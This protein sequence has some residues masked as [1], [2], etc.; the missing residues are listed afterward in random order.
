MS[1]AQEKPQQQPYAQ[2]PVPPAG[3]PA[4]GYPVQ[5]P[6]P[7]QPGQYGY[8]GQYQQPYPQQYV[9]QQQAPGLA[10]E[11][12][13]GPKPVSYGLRI[14]AAVVGL[15]SLM[16]GLFSAM[17]AFN[18]PAGVNGLVGFAV[19]LTI[20]GAL[21]TA[22]L[23]VLLLVQ[24]RAEKPKVLAALLAGAAG[25]MA[26]EFVAKQPL[27]GLVA[28]AVVILAGLAIGRDRRYARQA[29]GL[30]EVVFR[31]LRNATAVAALVQGIFNLAWM[32]SMGFGS[33]FEALGSTLYLVAGP[34]A[35]AAGA[36]LLAD[37]RLFGDRLSVIILGAGG[38]GFL[39]GAPLAVDTEAAIVNLIASIAALVL[40]LVLLLNERGSNPAAWFAPWPAQQ[41]PLPHPIPAQPSEQQ[42][43][44]QEA[45]QPAEEEVR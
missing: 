29:A 27:G 3:Y 12:P 33:V 26:V 21:G 11:K 9:Y 24:I 10:A 32:A 22:V 44:G 42:Q 19:A 36:L 45:E 5:P 13:A 7:Q 1:E 4:P 18:A 23:S 40:A 34:V 25:T 6:F 28:L 35:V 37:I 38:L 8:A 43:P 41:A 16:T 15:V 30:A 39:V 20:L 17:L 31:K 14:A 2:Q